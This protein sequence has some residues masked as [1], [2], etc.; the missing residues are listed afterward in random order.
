MKVFHLFAPFSCFRSLSASLD[1]L[2]QDSKGEREPQ[3]MFLARFRGRGHES[4]HEATQSRGLT[5][6]FSFVDSP[7]P[8][9]AVYTH[10][11]LLHT[12]EGPRRPDT[13]L[14]PSVTR[15]VVSSSGAGHT[16]V[17]FLLRS[18]RQPVAAKRSRA[19]SGSE[20]GSGGHGTPKGSALGSSAPG[21]RLRGVSYLSARTLRFE[22]SPP[23]ADRAS[24]P[25]DPRSEFD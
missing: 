16:A 12:A 13:P 20:R 9:S 6:L 11:G 8:A 7:P 22:G 1:G 23:D 2:G 18:L 15:G 3:L 14:L 21:D 19:R 24:A 5:H 4:G 17:H 25:F 10:K